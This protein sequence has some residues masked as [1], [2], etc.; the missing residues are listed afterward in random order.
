MLV[1][2]DVNDVMVNVV[3]FLFFVVGVIICIDGI[4][5]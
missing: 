5:D 4:V 1:F 3:L 2:Y